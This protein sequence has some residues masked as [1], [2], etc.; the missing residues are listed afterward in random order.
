MGLADGLQLPALAVGR[1][2]GLDRL[3]DGRLRARLRSEWQPLA[4]VRRRQDHQDL[5][6]GREC[7]KL[8]G[9]V[10]ITA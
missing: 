5:Q 1:A 2:V 9:L 8:S 3:R 6:R 4:H 7:G 10:Y